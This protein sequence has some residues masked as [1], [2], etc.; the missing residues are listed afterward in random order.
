MRSVA[1]TYHLGGRGLLAAWTSH[2]FASRLGL[3]AGAIIL[4][5]AGYVLATRFGTAA[6]PPLHFEVPMSTSPGTGA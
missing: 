2:R 1:Q 6:S 3:T 4:M 5:V